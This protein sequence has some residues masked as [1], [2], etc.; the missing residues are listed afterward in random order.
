MTQPLQPSNNKRELDT[1]IANFTSTA[2]K[3]GFIQAPPTPLLSDDPTLLFTNSTIAGYKQHLVEGRL[4]SP[5]FS[6]I[7]DCIRNQ[8]L[9]SI[10]NWDEDLKYMSCFTQL[11][12]LGCPKS[13]PR[14]LEFITYYFASISNREH[15]LC[16]VSRSLALYES[17]NRNVEAWQIETDGCSPGYYHWQY[18]LEGVKGEGVTYAILDQAV[19][20]YRDIGNLIEISTSSGVLGY[21]FGFG[22]ETLDSRLRGLDSPFESCL[23]ID[24]FDMGNEPFLKRKVLD[25]LMLAA[26]L[27]AI[28]VDETTLKRASILRRV[29]NDLFYLAYLCQL[30]PQLILAI[31][32]EYLRAKGMAEKNFIRNFSSFE[33]RV[34]VKINRAR[35]YIDYTTM[36]DKSWDRARR[37]CVERIGIPAVYFE[38]MFEPQLIL[39]SQINRNAKQQPQEVSDC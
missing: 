9:K 39:T 14:I 20:V 31:G 17:V 37:H 13:L 26:M 11:G 33:R 15:L 23:A 35:Q 34:G 30:E 3:F 10:R 16:R 7:Q 2:S 36:H 29:M 5:G 32:R 25:S 12:V 18:G 22:V 19:G 24:Y 1:L 27:C 28:G 38:K 8:N 21:E 6:I 4:P